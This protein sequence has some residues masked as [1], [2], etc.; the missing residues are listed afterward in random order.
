MPDIRQAFQS[1][2]LLPGHDVSSFDCGAPALNQWLRSEANRAQQ[3]GTARTTVWI[4]PNGL[5]AAFYSVCPTSVQRTGLP[6]SASGGNTVLPAY[7]LARL[8]LDKQLQGRHLGA[9]LLVDA[10]EQL[11]QATTRF[12]GRL[13]VVDAI[14]DRAA[15][16]YENFGF[17]LIS[18]SNRLYLTAASLHSAAEQARH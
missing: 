14:D 12:G 15:S 16:F 10:L 9:Q 4:D 1:T 6:R 5:V 13:V 18:G 7:L 2:R 17:H 8:A 3:Q 11:D